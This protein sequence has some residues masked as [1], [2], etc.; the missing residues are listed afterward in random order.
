MRAPRSLS[1]YLGII[2]APPTFLFA[3][4]AERGG[5]LLQCNNIDTREPGTKPSTVGTTAM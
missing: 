5:Y 3:A 1:N 4:K 2:S